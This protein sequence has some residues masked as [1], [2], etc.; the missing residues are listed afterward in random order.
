M[1]LPG[2]RLVVNFLVLLNLRS[3]NITD[4]VGLYLHPSREHSV[5]VSKDSLAGLSSGLSLKEFPRYSCV[6]SRTLLCGNAKFIEKIRCKRTIH[7]FGGQD[8]KPNLAAV[9][10]E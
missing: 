10:P 7:R 1:V 6:C 9:L 5:L 4:K 3:L 2:L 8:R